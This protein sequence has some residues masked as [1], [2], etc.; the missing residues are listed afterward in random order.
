M[1]KPAT[2]R[3]VYGADGP[4][5]GKIPMPPA[6]KRPTTR[7]DDPPVG[8][9]ADLLASLET[10]A[11]LA[12]VFGF[13]R[14]S[15]ERC[16][17]QDYRVPFLN[18]DGPTSCSPVGAGLG[19]RADEEQLTIGG[20]Q[21]STPGAIKA[22]PLLYGS[23]PP[24][25]RIVELVG[26]EGVT[27]RAQ[28][29]DA[30]P[31]YAHRAYYL[32]EWSTLVKTQARALDEQGRALASRTFGGTTPEIRAMQC[33]GA[34]AVTLSHLQGAVIAGQVYA[35]EQ[36][37][38]ADAERL[39]FPNPGPGSQPGDPVFAD[40]LVLQRYQLATAA[41]GSM[42]PVETYAYRMGA[43]VIGGDGADCFPEDVKNAAAEYFRASTGAAP[44]PSRF[45]K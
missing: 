15:G 16:T 45:G 25:T 12:R 6:A 14:Q 38:S 9:Q 35:K 28:A 36:P 34:R 7:T 31:A 19:P 4:E 11:G 40:S 2:T 32:A 18:S 42:G 13:T 33:R 29:R 22:P 8:T 21:D 44:L 30:G 39:R 41:I 3:T 20:G 1:T 5:L 43:V 23:A 24:G 10:S 37:A 26:E 17:G 27:F